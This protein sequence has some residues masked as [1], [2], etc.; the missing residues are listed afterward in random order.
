[1]RRALRPS[2]GSVLYAAVVVTTGIGLVLVGIGSW[3]TGVSVCGFGMLAAG[4]GR[5]VIPERNAGLLRV[6][7]RATDSFTMLALGASLIVLAI[8]LPDRPPGSP[9]VISGAESRAMADLS[10]TTLPTALTP[11]V[12]LA[13]LPR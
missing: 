8:V 1:M 11:A 2:L 10:D 3:R 12:R 13:T 4:L 5:L 7:R 6:R 9:G